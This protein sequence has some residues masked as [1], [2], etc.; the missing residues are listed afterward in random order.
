MKNEDPLVTIYVPCKDYIKYLQQSLES[1]KNQI[2]QNWELFVID[3]GSKINCKSLVDKF[4][5]DVKQE[6][7]FIRKNKS[8]GIQKIA[9]EVLK[10]SKGKYIIRLDADDWLS[11]TSLVSLVEKIEKNKK[12]NIVTSNYFIVDELGKIIGYDNVYDK[13]KKIDKDMSPPH[14]ACTLFKIKDLKKI[15]GYSTNIKAQ[16]GWEIW[17]KLDKGLNSDFID[18]PLFYYRKHNNSLSTNR[19]KILSERAKIFDKIN[20]IKN[21]GYKL[22][23]LAVIPAKNSYKN[24]KN[25]PFK[26]LNNKNLLEIAIQEANK[27]KYITSIIVSSDSDKVIKYVNNKYKNSKK[28]IIG[29]KEAK[30]D[31]NVN[32]EKILNNASGFFY[33]KNNYNPDIVIFLSLHA[34]LRKN[35]HIKKSIDFLCITNKNTIISVTK[36]YEPTFIKDKK[37]FRLI[38]TGRFKNNDLENES[39][40]KFN[41]VLI[42][43]WFDILK[44][45][46]IFNE[47]IG[48]IEMLSDESI[49]ITN[50]ENL[51]IAK[52][53]ITKDLI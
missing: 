17:F 26:K 23:C 31:E 47:K 43:T 8:V 35:V 19:N 3:D 24:F 14:G 50:K 11:E 51:Y 5:I 44:K 18:A 29:F 45:Q 33:K 40:F 20:S 27:C 34:P 6:V 30:K 28:Q 21:K 38:N 9:N 39:V 49:Q 16:D 53:I 52:K 22:N 13:E 32:L 2:Y 42:A 25:V 36:E 15:G 12:L 7:K 37:S 10:K 4:K 48:F 41:G 1:I 46:K